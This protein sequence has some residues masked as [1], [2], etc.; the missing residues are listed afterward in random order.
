MRPTAWQDYPQELWAAHWHERFDASDARSTL[1]WRN[2]FTNSI[3]KVYSFYSSTEDV[4][5]EYDDTPTA[6]VVQNAFQALT[7]GG[8]ASMGVYAWTIQEKCKGDKFNIL[9]SK[10]NYFFRVH[11]VL[12]ENGNVKSALYGKIYGDFMQF[13]YSRNVEFKQNLTK[14]INPLEG[15]SEP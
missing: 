10:R 13:H 4:L 2:R 1:T 3:S 12:D 11:T 7:G 6:A 15:V 9:D 14:N 5:G 8:I